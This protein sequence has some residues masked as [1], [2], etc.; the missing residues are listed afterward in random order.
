MGWL[1]LAR[2]FGAVCAAQRRSR[3]NCQGNQRYRPSDGLQRALV[4]SRRVSVLRA[5]CVGRRMRCGTCQIEPGRPGRQGPWSRSTRR[6]GP[7]LLKSAERTLNP[8]FSI[9][10]SCASSQ[11]PRV[12]GQ[13]A[14]RGPT[15]HR[16]SRAGQAGTSDRP[17]PPSDCFLRH[18][19]S[20]RLHPPSCIPLPAWIPTLCPSWCFDSES[21]RT[22]IPAIP[23]QR[24][25]IAGDMRYPTL[26]LAKR[27]TRTRRE[28]ATRPMH[29]SLTPSASALSCPDWTPRLLSSPS[30]AH[31]GSYS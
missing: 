8:R 23:A 9:K 26:D 1:G 29:P 5:A 24:S 7:A 4:C 12:L 14:F 19:S 22:A 3:R 11:V 30:S 10:V 25:M 28:K 18:A 17:L 20:A 6:V 16:G 2:W 21:P 27:S 15:K 13:R 31:R